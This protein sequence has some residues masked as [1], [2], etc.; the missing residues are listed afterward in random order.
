MSTLPR[1]AGYEGSDYQDSYV[2]FF[3]YGD[4]KEQIP[5]QIKIWNKVGLAYGTVTETAF[6]EDT[7]NDLRFF[8]S[9][10]ILVNQ[11]GV[12]NDD[13]Y[14]Y[15]DIGIPFMAQLGRELYLYERARKQ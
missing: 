1:E 8:L 4:S 12:F 14:E 2:K 9:A 6:I 10:T 15:E 13:I 11:N 5:S 7:V 3:L